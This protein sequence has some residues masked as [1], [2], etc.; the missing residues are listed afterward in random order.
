M[1]RGILDEVDIGGLKVAAFKTAL[2]LGIP[3]L[4][5]REPRSASA[6]AS[7]TGWDAK[8]LRVLFDCLVLMG[9]AE[10]VG[11]E[12]FKLTDLAEKFLVASNPGYCAPI[13]LDWLRNRERLTEAIRTGK[14]PANQ[15]SESS[16]ALWASD[17][18]AVLVEWPDRVETVTA[19]WRDLGVSR[20]KLPGARV[21]DVGCGAGL[22]S[23][24][25]ARADAAA[26]VV[27][28][29]RPIVLSVTR[30]LAEAMGVTSQVAFI[31]GDMMETSF[32]PASFDIVLCSNLL[33]FYRPEAV[34]GL[35]VKARDALRPGGRVFICASMRAKHGECGDEVWNELEMLTM[36][37][38]GT[39]YTYDQYQ[40]MAGNAGLTD[41][42]RHGSGML[43]ARK[44]GE[45]RA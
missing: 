19:R 37:P 38:E 40:A 9:L 35:L 43:S 18:A 31:E 24:A 44:P 33:H 42:E 6:L 21:L 16:A 45:G 15:A 32:G 13:Y 26:S 30:T 20:E 28:V 4:L 17:G 2:E 23:L 5:A 41:I 34:I 11:E 8:G 14:A 1:G 29:D 7:A 12:R 27:V 22:M 3:D 36:A 39:L 10:P 25:I